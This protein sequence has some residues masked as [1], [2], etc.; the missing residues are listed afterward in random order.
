MTEELKNTIKEE[1]LKLPKEMQQAINGLAWEKIAEEIGKKYS[2]SESEINHF[3]AETAIILLGI[4]N[5]DIYT[6]N[7]ETETRKPKD[8]AEKIADEAFEKIFKP[9]KKSIEDAVKSNMANKEMTWQQS[10][11]FILSGG[12]YSVLIERRQKTSA[13]FN[14]N[15]DI[16]KNKVLGTKSMQD[17]K[18]KL[19]N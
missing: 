2:L 13:N 12:D 11:D 3:Q 17:M 6:E 16:D 4:E 5:P 7:I 8:V 10:V 18:D 15:S 14:N 19:V 9:I 1:I